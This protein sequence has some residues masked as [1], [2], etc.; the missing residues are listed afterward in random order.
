MTRLTA[1]FSKVEPTINTEFFSILEKF[2]ELKELIQSQY[3]CNKRFQALC[4]NYFLCLKS[5]NGRELEMKKHKERYKE[6]EEL[7]RMLEEKML[8][9]IRGIK[10]WES[11]ALK[12]KTD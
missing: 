10:N 12:S 5:L 7:K 6:Y 1:Y 8:Q 9:Y 4:L 11:I 3:D 2:P